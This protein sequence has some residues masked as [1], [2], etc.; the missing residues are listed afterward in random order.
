MR[1]VII[2]ILISAVFVFMVS[3][4]PRKTQPQDFRVIVSILPQKFLVDKISGGN[5]PCEVM[6][7]PGGNHE[8]FEPSPRDMA[9]VADASVY[10]T[11]GALDFEK[12]WIEKVKAV[13]P[14]IEIVNTSK[15]IQM[16]E[17]H[18][19]DG[20]HNHSQDPHTWLSP[21][22]VK[23]Q[24]G[25]I[26]ESLCRLSPGDSVTFRRNLRLFTNEADSATGVIKRLLS[27]HSGKTFIIYHPALAYFAREFGLKQESIEF[28]GKE[29]S[30]VH[31]REIIDIAQANGIKAI[32]VSREFDTRH[33][34]TIASQIGGEL[35]TFDPMAY[36]WTT[37]IIG[38][39]NL[40]AGSLS[41]QSGETRPAK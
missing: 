14:E 16:I 18:S 15:G 22:E 7:P 34:Q 4:N 30:P 6:V 39:A 35:V 33:A 13:N 32:L 21:A 9:R 28:E 2:P 1:I 29:P 40:I 19:H 37:N 36:D 12:A 17:G 25:S 41:Q 20:T 27:S 23:I 3:C 8:T 31:M 24:A 5:L 11:I 38:I 26:C 10:Y